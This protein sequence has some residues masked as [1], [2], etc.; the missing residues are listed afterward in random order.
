MKTISSACLERTATACPL[1]WDEGSLIQ[2]IGRAARNLQGEAVG[3][4]M[5]SARP[6]QDR[7]RYGSVDETLPLAPEQAV[8]RIKKL[9]AEMMKRNLDFEQAGRSR[10]QIQELRD[11]AF[12]VPSRRA[13]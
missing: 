4:V 12:G 3:D 8:K 7:G 5:E 9:E 2:T 11:V 6:V 1:E 10:D 13:G